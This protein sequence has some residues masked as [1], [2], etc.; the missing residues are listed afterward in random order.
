MLKDISNLKNNKILVYLEKLEHFDLFNQIFLQNPE[1][2]FCIH[3]NLIN[4]DNFRRSN[5]ITLDNVFFLTDINR[6]KFQIGSFKAFITTNAYSISSNEYVLHLIKKAKEQSIP[7]IKVQT[8]L[9]EPLVHFDSS[10][11]KDVYSDNSF[12]TESLED[13]YLSFYPVNY[14]KDTTVIGY[15]YFYKNF[16]GINESYGLIISNMDWNP[17]SR[18]DIHIFYKTIINFIQKSTVKSFIWK[19]NPNEL[20]NPVCMQFLVNLFKVFPN[21]KEKILF[22]HEN[23][24]LKKIT[25]FELIK[26]S[27]FVITSL[28]NKILDCEMLKKKTMIY[29]CSNINILTRKLKNV[30]LFQNIDELD[31]IFTQKNQICSNL[32]FKFDNNKFKE[33]LNKI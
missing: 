5:L 7:V 22:C 4:V 11:K 31:T 26:K 21:T 18:D 24:M 14:K 2:E 29:N 15:P 30:D 8:E 25:D 19:M 32:L 16:T 20:I 28:N 6:L 3:S 13:Y 9:F 12:I 10:L 23:E 27:S 1:L 33:V 17:Y